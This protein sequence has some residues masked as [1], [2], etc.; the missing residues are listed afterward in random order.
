VSH[1]GLEAPGHYA[2]PHVHGAA[3]V[4][5]FDCLPAIRVP[6]GELFAG[7]PDTTM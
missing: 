6:I 3:E 4:M 2:D 5:S 1:Y 7:A